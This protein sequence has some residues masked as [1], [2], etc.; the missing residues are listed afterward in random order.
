MC[1]SCFL[2][3]WPDKKKEGKAE[4]KISEIKV[5][6]LLN[7]VADFFHNFTDGLAIG[8]SFLVSQPVGLV[9]TATIFFHEVSTMCRYRLYL[10]SFS[11]EYTLKSNFMSSG[12]DV[13]NYK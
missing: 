13:T 4:P 2:L 3:L 11:S 1:I 10:A 8:A 6:G 12:A 5:A 7:L 9:T